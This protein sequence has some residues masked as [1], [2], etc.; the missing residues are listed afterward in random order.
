LRAVRKALP[1]QRKLAEI[2]GVAP[3][4]VIN[5]IRGAGASRPR[6]IT[7]SKKLGLDPQWL[8]EGKG[9]ETAQLAGSRRSSTILG[10]TVQRA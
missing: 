9:D 10:T 4:T 3:A 6:L 5:W 2:G 8:L 7:F 1:S